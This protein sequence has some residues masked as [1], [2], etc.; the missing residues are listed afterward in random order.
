MPNKA[1]LGDDGLLHQLYIGDQTA[2]TITDI[3]QQSEA[4]MRQLQK[5]D[6]PIN[7]LVD[8]SKIGHQNLGARRVA[9]YVLKHWP[10]RKIAI[11]GASSY[12]RH[13][14][15]LMVLANGRSHMVRSFASQQAA[16]DWLKK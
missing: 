1:F 6:K 11:F 4:V 9:S 12:L 2:E 5:Q 8:L 13:V 7:I 14:A 3:V 16:T 10:Y 15:N